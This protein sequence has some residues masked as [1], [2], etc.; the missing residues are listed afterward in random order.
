M[1]IRNFQDPAKQIAKLRKKLVKAKNKAEQAEYTLRKLALVKAALEEELEDC[2]TE[3]KQLRQQLLE[4]KAQIDHMSRD[5]EGFI[6]LR[7]KE[8]IRGE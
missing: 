3:N 5:A 6:L 7:H 2:S 8:V 4:L 1:K